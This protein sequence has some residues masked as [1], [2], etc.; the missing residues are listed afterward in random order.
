MYKNICVTNRALVSDK[1][2]EDKISEVLK[3]FDIDILIL[4]E[5]DLHREDFLELS[6]KIKK[7]CDYNESEFYINY[8]YE[9]ARE[10]N[11]KNVAL[12]L[13]IAEAA[14]DLSDFENIII[15][16]HDKD[17]IKRAE[18]IG[19]TALMFGN[20]FETTCKPGKAGRGVEKLKEIVGFSSL[21]VYAIGGINDE[22]QE[23]SVLQAGA[24]GIAKMSFYMTNKIS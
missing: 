9:I 11:V 22:K 10:L 12:P 23:F 18:N 7:I 5:K 2:F 4:R 1:S 6:K 17:E 19:A 14:G 21:P 3:N 15:S 16:I 8:F 20:V 13:K 24:E